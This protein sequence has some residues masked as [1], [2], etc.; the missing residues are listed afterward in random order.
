MTGSRG[1]SRNFFQRGGGGGS[2]VKI[3]GVHD[4]MYNT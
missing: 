1:K 2:R 3:K 4:K